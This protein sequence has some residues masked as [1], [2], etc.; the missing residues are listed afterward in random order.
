MSEVP[1]LPDWQSRRRSSSG[2][3][4]IEHSE[5]T[6]DGLADLVGSD[7]V[8][9]LPRARRSRSPEPEADV[10]TLPRALRSTSAPAPRLIPIDLDT[11]EPVTVPLAERPQEP[12]LDGDDEVP[13][14]EIV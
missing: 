1:T 9:T 13:T 10:A 2:V 12:V 3:R 6:L 4:I 11:C 8:E 14:Y 5:P 7:D